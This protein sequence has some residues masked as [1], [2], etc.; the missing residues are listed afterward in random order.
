[1]DDPAV[2][3]TAATRR[4]AR[5]PPIRLLVLD[6]D[7]TVTDTRHEVPT[8]TRRAVRAVLDAGIRVMLATGRRYRDALPVARTLGLDTPLVTASGAL[9]KS[10]VD[11]ATLHRAGF[12]KGVLERALAT[13]V[14]AGHEPIVYSDRYAD[15]FDF[16][17]RRLTVTT[18][19]DDGV[20]AEYL[21][22]NAEV[23]RVHPDL[24]ATPPP[25]VFAGFA[26]G[27]R[28]AMESLEAD[29]HA[30]CPAALSLHTL[31][32]PRYRHWMCEIAPATVTKWSAVAAVAETWGISPQEICAAGDDVNDL[33]M[34]EAS[35]LG[36]AMGNARPEVL[37]AADRVVGTNDGGG[38]GDIAELLFAR[39]AQSAPSGD[40]AGTSG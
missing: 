6:I 17:C 28:E 38:I 8:A 31:R 14:A 11:H 4:D 5:P 13:V 37:V 39:L 3:S 27:S 2:P 20:L 7:G 9:V 10:P 30:A 25:D 18:T 34:I 23:A 29:L 26:M 16:Y 32:S 15:G 19:T 35:G 36:I 12:A 33:P 22:R 40:G 21:A 24:H 1:M